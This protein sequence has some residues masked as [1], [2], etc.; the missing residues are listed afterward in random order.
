MGI[1]SND[2]GYFTARC[3]RTLSVY[4]TPDKACVEIVLGALLEGNRE[5]SKEI[6]KRYFFG[7]SQLLIHEKQSLLCGHCIVA[8]SRVK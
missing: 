4:W 3:T 1:K 5:D 8:I 7:Q 6:P 2:G